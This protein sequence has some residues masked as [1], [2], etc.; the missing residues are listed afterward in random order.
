MLLSACTD[1]NIRYV[2]FS[3]E[4]NVINVA[5]SITFVKLDE[6]MG[7]VDLSAFDTLMVVRER[8]PADD[9]FLHIYDIRSFEHLAHIGKIG[10]GP[11]E[12]ILPGYINSHIDSSSFWLWDADR[13]IQWRYHL[14]SMLVDPNYQPSE[15]VKLDIIMPICRFAM[16]DDS[17]FLGMAFIPTSTSTF[18]TDMVKFN[19]HSG[20]VAHYGYQHEG[21]SD[22]HSNS[23]FAMS[24]RENVYVQAHVYCQLLSIFNA[25]GSLRCDVV[26]DDYGDDIQDGRDYFGRVLITGNLIVVGYNGEDSFRLDKYKRMET[27]CPT[28]LLVFDLDGNHLATIE[29]GN[30]IVSFCIDESNN[31]VI[32]YFNGCENPLGYFNF[33]FKGLLR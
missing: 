8:F 17:T 32:C 19:T 6:V 15:F 13:E 9:R 20:K 4:S 33:D 7:T 16:T 12:V 30:E 27:T 1:S 10:K 3:P 29:T 14:D 18:R 11:N 26:G 23:L 25:D 28:K 21:L 31:R 22:R 2:H 5:D 24:L